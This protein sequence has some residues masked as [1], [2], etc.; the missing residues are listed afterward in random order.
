MKEIRGKGL[1]VFALGVALAVSL[2]AFGQDA[3]KTNASKAANGKTADLEKIL[4]AANEQWLCAGPYYKAKA[5]DCVDARAKFWADQFFEIY[6]NGGVHTKADMVVSQSEGA[7]KN[8]NVVPGQ[9]PNPTE[10][11]LMAL[12]G[13]VALGV[14]RTIFKAPDASGKLGTTSQARVLRIFVKENG[15]WRPASAALITIPSGS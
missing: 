2:L 4:A 13:N 3:G 11:K 5:Q 9:G 15:K 7:A 6:P 10:F 14:D 1:G 8:P 12:Y